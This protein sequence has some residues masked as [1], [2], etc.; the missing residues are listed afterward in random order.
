MSFLHSGEVMSAW[1]VSSDRLKPVSELA[2]SLSD[3]LSNVRPDIFAIDY[4][5]VVMDN[6][7]RNSRPCSVDCICVSKDRLLF[8]EFKPLRGDQGMFV[9]KFK[10]KALESLIVFDKMLGSNMKKEFI[11]VTQDPRDVFG[12]SILSKGLGTAVPESLNRFRMCDARGHRLFFDEVSFLSCRQFM[13]HI[14]RCGEGSKDRLTSMAERWNSDR[15][16]S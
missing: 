16:G 15:F 5:G 11:V 1:C 7:G 3:S 4:D 2:D 9:E 6:S 10:C 8:I 13:E 12:C 14:Q